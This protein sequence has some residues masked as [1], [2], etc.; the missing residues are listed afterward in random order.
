MST[1]FHW[2]LQLPS[3]HTGAVQEPNATHAGFA[4]IAPVG[5]GISAGAQRRAQWLC[6]AATSG[7]QECSTGA[8]AGGGAAALAVP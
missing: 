3:H 7:S 8:L 6:P 1:K 4:G 2:Y 5:I